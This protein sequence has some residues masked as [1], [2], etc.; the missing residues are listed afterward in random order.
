MT[1]FVATLHGTRYHRA[2]C[3][4][5]DAYGAP[6]GVRKVNRRKIAA[7]GLLPCK[8]CEPPLF[9]ALTVIEGGG[10]HAAPIGPAERPG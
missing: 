7:Q 4:R 10:D 1:D 5:V 9:P 6:N 2:G 8:E 3:V